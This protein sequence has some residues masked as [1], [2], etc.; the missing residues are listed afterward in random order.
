MKTTRW[1]LAVPLLVVLIQ[2]IAF[3]PFLPDE[4]ASHFDAAGHP[5]GW[6]SKSGFFLTILAVVLVITVLFWGLSA[7]IRKLPARALSLPRKDYWMAPERRDETFDFLGRQLAFFGFATG[8]F[9]VVILQLTIHANMAQDKHL[10]TTF[11]LVFLGIYLAFTIG[12][13][14]GFLLKFLRTA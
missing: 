2:I 6:S 13:V 3:H 5:N 9:F 11:F 1:L 8:W 4:V 10:D 14:V 12:W 7:G